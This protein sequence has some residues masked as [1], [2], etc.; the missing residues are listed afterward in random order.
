[1][2][3]LLCLTLTMLTLAVFAAAFTT[4]LAGQDEP[5]KKKKKDD[6]DKPPPGQK[7]FQLGKVLP[8]GVAKDLDL[9]PDQAK[10]LRELEMEVKER[11]EKILTPEQREKVKNF[12]PGPPK[13]KGRD[14]GQDKEKKDN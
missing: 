9:T 8:P 11:L 12:R 3:K 1:M 7:G 5:E 14:K 13:D 10:A 2:R 4:P 6:G